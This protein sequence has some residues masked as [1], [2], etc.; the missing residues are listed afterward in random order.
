MLVFFE[1]SCPA[2]GNL[3]QA[4]GKVP[5]L[6]ANPKLKCRYYLKLICKN[7]QL[8]S[9]QQK[10]FYI[11]LSVRNFLWAIGKSETNINKWYHSFNEHSI[12]INDI[13]LYEIYYLQMSHYYSLL[14]SNCN[15]QFRSEIYFLSS[16]HWWLCCPAVMS[17][18]QFFAWE[19]MVSEIQSTIS[20]I[21]YTCHLHPL[22]AGSS[23]IRS[24]MAKNS[25]CSLMDVLCL[26]HLST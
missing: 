13:L 10:T 22:V 23:V 3:G 2:F 25:E 5:S 11:V 8:L 4:A 17:C 7:Q 9:I 1:F 19:N 24:T 6:L 18:C 12:P 21:S 15:W 20:H 26:A 14:D 16:G